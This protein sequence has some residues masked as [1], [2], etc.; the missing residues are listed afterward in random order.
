MQVS[1]VTKKIIIKPESSLH[2]TPSQIT[3]V[4]DTSIS[5]SS[6]ALARKRVV[7]TAVKDRKANNQEDIAL[8]KVEVSGNQ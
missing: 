1:R 3:T 7:A 5:S 8:S 4:A 2:M 6:N